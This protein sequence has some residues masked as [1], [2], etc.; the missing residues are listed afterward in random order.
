MGSPRYPTEAQIRQLRGAAE[1]SAPEVHE[2]RNGS[3]TIK[4]PAHGLALL[5]LRRAH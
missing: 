4:I 1:L 3:V 5:E 2:L